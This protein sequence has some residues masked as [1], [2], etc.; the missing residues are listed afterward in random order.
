M[1]HPTQPLVMDAGGVLRFK[2]N[3]IV[4]YLLDSHPTCD[5]NKLAVMSFSNE[6]RRQFAQ[7]IGY[8]E[9][10]YFDLSYA[11]EEDMP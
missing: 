9:C 3:A 2:A 10:G 7:L 5:L 8:S 11:N 6:D 4:Q 1:T